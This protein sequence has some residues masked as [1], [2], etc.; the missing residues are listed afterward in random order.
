MPVPHNFKLSPGKEKLVKIGAGVSNDQ[1]R[2]WCIK[3]RLQ[4]DA[5]VIMVE[6][7]FCGAL[8]TCSH[9][10][11]IK[12][13]PLCDSIVEIEFVNCKGEFQTINKWDHPELIGSAAGS[14]GLI[15][16][17]VSVTI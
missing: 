1:L 16:L 3:H 12:N 17:Y 4:Y 15:G 9:G 10:S 8:G 6:V 13:P 7:N 11:G 5:N 2:R 14:L